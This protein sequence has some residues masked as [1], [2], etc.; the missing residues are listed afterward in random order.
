MQQL[1]EGGSAPQGAEPPRRDARELLRE[2]D[3]LALRILA[4][5]R[6]L[7]ALRDAHAAE[8][9]RMSSELKRHT[10]VL[11]AQ[12]RARGPLTRFRLHRQ[13]RGAHR[14]RQRWTSLRVSSSSVAS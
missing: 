12:T 14:M 5:Q 2:R 10:R 8:L 4:A 11:T 13:A 1:S 3:D 7:D 9:A 6:E